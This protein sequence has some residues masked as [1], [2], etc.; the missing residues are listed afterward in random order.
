M[1]G[2]LEALGAST[3]YLWVSEDPFL[4]C[5]LSVGVVS[6][7]FCKITECLPYLWQMMA[8]MGVEP[9]VVLQIDNK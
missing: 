1:F 3:K 5:T 9:N 2:L 7:L 8:L 4:G 6:L